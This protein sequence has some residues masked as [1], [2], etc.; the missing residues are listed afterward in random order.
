MLASH[1]ERIATAASPAAIVSVFTHDAEV[2]VYA[3]ECLRIVA[4]GFVFF[5]YGMVAVQAF[6]GAGD[7]VTPMILNVGCFW[8][9]KI[10]LAWLL[11]KHLGLG[12]RGVFLSIAAAYSLQALIAYA[13]FRQGSWQKRKIE[14]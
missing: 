4:L 14:A 8:F 5:A 11:S 13:L 12:P 6:N 3:S 9:F 2:V 10:P 7:T 1:S